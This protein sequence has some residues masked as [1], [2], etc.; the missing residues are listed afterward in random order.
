MK[1]AHQLRFAAPVLILALTVAVPV[2][3]QSASSSFHEAGEATENAGSSVG[4][5]AVHAYHGTV[6]ATE[7]TAITTDVKTKLL[8]DGLTKNGEIHVTTVAGVV[9]LR[10]HVPTG[11][12]ASQAE[13]VAA[14]SDGVKQVRNRLRIRAAS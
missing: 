1:V 11:A 14:S 6:T 2:W 9:T 5:A 12:I 8:K 4:H 10:G 7:D 13:H 3:A